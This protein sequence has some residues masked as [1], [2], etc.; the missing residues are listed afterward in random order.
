MPGARSARGVPV[1]ILLVMHE[2]WAS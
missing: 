1:L 2:V